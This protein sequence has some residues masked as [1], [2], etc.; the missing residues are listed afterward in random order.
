[1]A[2]ISNVSN[3]KNAIGED[4]LNWNNSPKKYLSFKYQKNAPSGYMVSKKGKGKTEYTFWNNNKFQHHYNGQYQKTVGVCYDIPNFTRKEI[5]DIAKNIIPKHAHLNLLGVDQ[6]NNHVLKNLESKWH[7]NK[8]IAMYDEEDYFFET[9]NCGINMTAEINQKG[10]MSGRCAI[11]N[12]FMWLD[13]L[14]SI[15]DIKEPKT[16]IDVGAGIGISSIYYAYHHPNCTVYVDEAN[17]YSVQF[18]NEACKHLNIK[19][20]IIGDELE[21]YDFGFFFE[22]VEHIQSNYDTKIGQP[23]PWADNYLNKIKTGLI[24]RTYWK[25]I[26]IGHFDKYDFDGNVVDVKKGGTEFKKC[27]EKRGWKKDNRH[28]F[29]GHKPIF[30]WK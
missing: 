6:K 15:G 1:M 12:G 8:D 19:N 20:I 27:M 9:V 7:Q 13:H 3:D 2:T 22:V 10:N 25:G 11:Y 16:I 30:F 28:S 5:L 17:P 26:H 24:Y 23:F 14:V 21:S 4:I 29:F 18:I